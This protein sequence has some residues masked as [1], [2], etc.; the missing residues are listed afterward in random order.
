MHHTTAEARRGA[1]RHA[2]R[3]V[4]SLLRAAAATEPPRLPPPLASF[5]GLPAGVDLA[6]RRGE[7]AENAGDGSVGGGG[8]GELGGGGVGTL[9]FAAF[10]NARG[11]DDAPP[12]LDDGF[13]A[14]GAA[15]A[16]PAARWPPAPVEVGGGG[17]AVRSLGDAFESEAV[18]VAGAFL[19]D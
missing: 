4:R 7:P 16:P 14:G 13:R 8:G 11:T 1:A 5:L 3:F 9:S 10:L 6:L 18:S 12:P 19:K 2:E 15:T 17:G